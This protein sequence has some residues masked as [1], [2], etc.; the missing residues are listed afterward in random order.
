MAAEGRVTGKPD[1]VTMAEEI[2]AMVD[3]IRSC[4]GTAR[5]LEGKS[6]HG[7]DLSMYG[8]RTAPASST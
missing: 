2:P 8:S 3:Q 4:S 7:K 5:L 6:G 1:H